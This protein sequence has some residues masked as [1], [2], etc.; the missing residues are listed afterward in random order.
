MKQIVEWELVSHCNYNCDY[1]LLPKYN[2][3]NDQIKIKEFIHNTLKPFRNEVL[4]C[5]GG[6]PFLHKN[7]KF[8]IDELNI[9]NQVF[10][11]Q[12]NLSLLSLDKIEI[13]NLTNFKLN[14]S[15]HPTQIDLKEI[16]YNLKKLI[17]LS[18][19][20]NI[21]IQTIDIMYVGEI[22]VKYYNILKNLFKLNFKLTPISGFYETNSCAKTIEYNKLRHENEFNN[23]I[24]FEEIITPAY[25]IYRSEVWEKQCLDEITTLN[26][27][28]YYKNRYF[29]FDSMLNINNCCYREFNTTG[30]CQHSKCFWM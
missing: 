5:F 21:S 15:I 19:K 29:L 13:L 26:Q 12:S 8:I 27:E 2:Y 14:G 23:N 22:S 17:Q 24:I 9:V 16:I 6:E 30:I 10:E 4:F 28:C 3:I 20:N 11:I 7:I 25:D 1:C 18:E